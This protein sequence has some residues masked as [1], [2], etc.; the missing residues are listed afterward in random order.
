MQRGRSRNDI[1]RML[2][3][4]EAHNYIGRDLPSEGYIAVHTAI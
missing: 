1:Y 4:L 2:Q 3:M